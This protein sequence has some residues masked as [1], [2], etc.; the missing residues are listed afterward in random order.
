MDMKKRERA[1]LKELAEQA[2]EAELEAELEELYEQFCRWADKGMSALELSG[3]IHKFHDGT[4]RELY[5]RYAGMDVATAVSRAIGVGILSEAALDETLRLKL[6][7]QIE[8][9]RQLRN[10]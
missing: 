7:S 2:W 8:F 9:F 6:A 10:E 1:M 3:E 5:N 4:A